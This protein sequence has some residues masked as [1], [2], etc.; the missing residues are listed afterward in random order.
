MPDIQCRSH[1]T[2]MFS[3]SQKYIAEQKGNWQ[4]T[5]REGYFWYETRSQ[6]SQPLNC[7]IFKEIKSINTV[8]WLFNV[9]WQITALPQFKHVN[10][11]SFHINLKHDMNM[12]K[13]QTVFYLNRG[14]QHFSSLSPPKL[15]CSSVWFVVKARREKQW[16]I[17]GSVRYD[18]VVS[19]F[20]MFATR[21][22]GQL[23][24]Y[25]WGNISVLNHEGEPMD[26]KQARVCTWVCTRANCMQDLCR[27]TS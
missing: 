13:H 25:F 6:D 26:I 16:K 3:H 14:I 9:S 2:L 27:W 7:V 21:G 20:G 8:L 12:N 18:T 5:D 11:T 10:R 17:H 24:K 22:A 1:T 23:V 19:R 4:H 15:I